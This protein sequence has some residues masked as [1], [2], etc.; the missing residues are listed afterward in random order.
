MKYK[1]FSITA[2]SAA[3]LSEAIDSFF[4]GNPD[5]TVVSALQSQSSGSDGL[6]ITFTAIYKPAP[7]KNEVS[8]FGFNAM[9]E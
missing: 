4:E 3:L 7:K 2:T 5:I 1:T 9:R 8:G 6:Q